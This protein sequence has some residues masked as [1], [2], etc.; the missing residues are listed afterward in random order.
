VEGAGL[1]GGLGGLGE[2]LW[3]E[4]VEHVGCGSCWIDEADGGD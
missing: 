1:R 3:R 4:P 2:G